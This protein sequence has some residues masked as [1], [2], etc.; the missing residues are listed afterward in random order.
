IFE[1]FLQA[2]SFIARERESVIRAQQLQMVAQNTEEQKL[3]MQDFFE[4]RHNFV[5]E[6]IVLKAELE[7][8]DKEA[9]RANLDKLI[10]SRNRVDVICTSGNSTVDAIINFKYA[11]AKESGIAF[12][13]KLFIPPELP[14]AQSDLGVILGNAVDNAIEAVKQCST[15][16]KVIEISMGVKKGACILVIKNPYEGKLETGHE[17]IPLTTKEQ[18]RRHGY[19]L[20]SIFRIAEEYEGE[21]VIDAAGGTFS[22]TVVLNLPV[23]ICQV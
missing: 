9:V 1:F 7:H 10:S 15:K 23:D 3:M 16:Q 18:K 13:L 6:L 4:Q 17:G 12:D 22:L 2:N 19:G 5:N 14:I 20:K 8:N 21:A 11:A